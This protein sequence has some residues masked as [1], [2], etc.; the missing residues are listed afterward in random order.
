MN[1]QGMRGPLPKSVFDVVA[2][3]TSH[4]GRGWT[5]E[6]DA[7]HGVG[8]LVQLAYE[9]VD[10]T[11]DVATCGDRSRLSTIRESAVKAASLLLAAID[12]LDAAEVAS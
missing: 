2:E 3:R 4:E 1:L 5:Q 7:E 6:H 10:R 8:H 11:L 12:L 9:Y